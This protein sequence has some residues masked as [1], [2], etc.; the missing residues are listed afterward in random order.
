MVIRALSAALAVALLTACGGNSGSIV[1]QPQGSRATSGNARALLVVKIP[2]NKT[3]A[4]RHPQYISPNTQSISFAYTIGTTKY[5]AQTLNVTPSSPGCS[6]DGSGNTVCTLAFGANAGTAN[7]TVS[8]Y[9]GQNGTGN[10][11]ASAQSSMAIVAGKDNAFNITLDGVPAS[12]ALS[13]SGADSTGAIPAG[14]VANVGL[15]ISAYDADKNLIVNSPA[16]WESGAAVST[17]T[18]SLAPGSTEFT[19]SQNGQ[20]LTPTGGAY[21]LAAPFSGVNIA[22]NGGLMTDLTLTLGAGSLSAQTVLHVEPVLTMYTLPDALSTVY[23]ITAGSDGNV[24]FTDPGTNSVGK[25]TPAG[26][27]TEY[28][29]QVADAGPNSITKDSSGNIWIDEGGTNCSCLA[30]ISNA[31]SVSATYAVYHSGCQPYPVNVAVDKSGNVWYTNGACSF[32]G[33]VNPATGLGK[34]FGS[35]TTDH[36]LLAG[37]DGNVWSTQVSSNGAQLWSID[38][39]GTLTK[40]DTQIQAADF[41]T[42]GNDGNLWFT[43]DTTSGTSYVGYMDLSTHKIVSEYPIPQQSGTGWYPMPEEL[44]Q[45][46]DGNVWFS[47]SLQQ[48]TFGFVAPGTGRVTQP[49]F[50]GNPTMPQKTPGKLIEGPDGNLWFSNLPTASATNENVIGKI[51]IGNAKL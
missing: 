50:Y 51:T 39:S 46:A 22:Y 4:S 11:L 10:M 8:A 3:A 15:V 25:M 1:P 26:A 9:D 20:T 18:L 6:V 43:D 17:A 40:Y 44:A 30:R 31:G 33:Y 28:P 42:I 34:V 7:Y 13:L 27:V 12:F 14:T 19:V 16:Y 5:S 29:L 35:I 38:A 23:D 49:A 47:E 32:I 24:W 37:P 41:L 48:N 2:K 21:A 36:P 45:G